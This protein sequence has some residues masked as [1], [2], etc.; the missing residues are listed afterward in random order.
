[1]YLYV[2]YI[3]MYRNV[4]HKA[5]LQKVTTN[6]V[7]KKNPP[8]SNNYENV[9]PESIK[10]IPAYGKRVVGAAVGSG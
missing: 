5:L 4:D 7:N 8:V 9:S 2:L 1:M 6:L 10:N 3:Y